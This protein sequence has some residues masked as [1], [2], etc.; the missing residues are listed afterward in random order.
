[1]VGCPHEWKID[2]RYIPYYWGC[3][4]CGKSV[5]DPETP[6]GPAPDC[7]TL[8]GALQAARYNSVYVMIDSFADGS[9][10]GVWHIND[11]DE[12]PSWPVATEHIAAT[13]ICKL[14]LQATNN[15]QE[16]DDE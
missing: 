12:S 16:T 15:P 11:D 4:R 5:L 9:G 6:P 10:Y 7:S 3:K 8:W 1:M 13:A 14:I 2:Q